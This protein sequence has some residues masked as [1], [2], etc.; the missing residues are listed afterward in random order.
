MKTY[1]EQD[2]KQTSHSAVGWNNESLEN[3][4]D[5]SWRLVTRKISLDLEM[6]MLLTVFR[7]LLRLRLET[8]ELP[9]IL[10]ETQ[11]SWNTWKRPN[12][13]EK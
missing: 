4:E 2:G 11:Q 10:V 12:M 6:R 5:G 9:K 13:L 3:S 8:N 7:K 1:L